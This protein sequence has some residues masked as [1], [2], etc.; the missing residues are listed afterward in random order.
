MDPA[1]LRELKH[2]TKE[3]IIAT[4]LSWSSPTS[5]H[6][7]ALA[8]SI[9]AATLVFPASWWVWKNRQDPVIHHR[10]FYVMAG[11]I[12]WATIM[13]IGIGGV[14]QPWPSWNPCPCVVYNMLVSGIL[15]CHYAMDCSRAVLFY[16]LAQ[17]NLAKMEGKVRSSPY[18]DRFIDTIGWLCSPQEYNRV[19][20]RLRV[21]TERFKTQLVSDV[22][23]GASQIRFKSSDPMSGSS[24]PAQ[25]T[26]ISTQDSQGTEGAQMRHT[27]GQVRPREILNWL[28]KLAVIFAVGSLVGLI[29]PMIQTGP[30]LQTLPMKY[31]YPFCFMNSWMVAVV[32]IVGAVTVILLSSLILFQPNDGMIIKTELVYFRPLIQ[33]ITICVAYREVKGLDYNTTHLI[34]MTA[35]AMQLA[36]VTLFPLCSIIGQSISKR[37]SIRAA[38]SMNIRSA[39][40]IEA[41]WAT[42]VGREV[43]GSITHA[44]YAYEIYRFL[45]DSNSPKCCQ[46]PHA[47]RIYETYICREAPFELNLRSRLIKEWEA[48][49]ARGEVKYELVAETRM[50]VFNDLLANYKHKIAAALVKLQTDETTYEY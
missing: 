45:I 31:S 15:F 21:L 1:L 26:G 9:V 40:D 47:R 5:L 49:V 10:T 8:L 46:A 12:V 41:L 24:R 14:A 27:T 32:L 30:L 37:R 19:T 42:K 7:F 3:Q 50:G 17:L 13:V 38:A 43:I 48:A 22:T 18:E 39:K 4:R 11:E 28:L 35:L 36:S 6:I 33:G 23:F 16:R 2:Y 25:E 34:I 20:F 29:L 44:A